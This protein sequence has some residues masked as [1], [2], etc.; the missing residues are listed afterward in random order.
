MSAQVCL[1]GFL[2]MGSA[3]MARSVSSV[4]MIR[5]LR[6]ALLAGVALSMATAPV[7]AETLQEALETTYETN[8][9][10]LAAR[11]ELRATDEGV[12]QAKAG[13]RPTVTLRATMGRTETDEPIETIREPWQ[14]TVSA[15][16]PIFSGGRT[17]AAFSQ[18]KALVR[19]G[20]ASLLSTEQQVLLS[21][22]T[23]YMD[24]LRDTAVV[25]LSRNQVAVLERQRQASQDRFDVG[26]IT[27]TDV[28]QAEA[29]LSRART[30]LI[31][32][33]AQL[34][35]SRASYERVVGR[36]P[37]G[38]EETTALP[39]LPESLE[40]VIAAARERN[41]QLVAAREIERASS[42]GIDRAIGAM[43]PTV[44]LDA[45]WTRGD[46]EATGGTRNES[47]TVEGVL[48][49]PI[50]QGGAEYSSIREARET[51]SQNMLEIAEAERSVIEQATNAW[52]NLRAARSSI[53][54]NRKQVEASVIAY[55]GVEQEAEVGARTT[56]DV[57]DAEQELLDA[58]VSLVRAERDQ[59][60]AAYALLASMG[61]LDAATLGLNVE[62]YNPVD[63]YDGVVG[64]WLGFLGD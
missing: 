35:A 64:D 27:R 62:I 7:S 16:Q 50:Y 10:L 44:S 26:E 25:E 37:E 43:L 38:L 17:L 21:A 45:I 5:A 18:A 34:A 20:R 3:A 59:L 23:A 6:A 49:M 1:P 57:L 19:A 4:R 30:S 41:P 12:Q 28:A 29:R 40:A 39:P 13:W 42:Y 56:L 14:T 22:V 55:E 61:Q 47:T 51:N 63:H 9:T 15:S 31:A 52:E 58:R 36:A 32:A 60:V 53:E 24:V 54:S 46:D 33:E 2:C 48:T 11:A 8:P